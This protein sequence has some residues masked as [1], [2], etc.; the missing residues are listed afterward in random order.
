MKWDAEQYDAGK[1]PQIDAGR[2]LIGLA[3]AREQ[4]SILDL[5]CG[6]GKL[7]VE[8]ARLAPKGRVTGLD[9][10]PEMLDKARAVSGG[11]A[12]LRL[13]QL[14]AQTMEFDDEFDLVFSNS[15]LQ[16]VKEQEDVLHRVYRSLRKGGRIAFQ[17]PMK[18]FC[19][20]FFDAVE[21]A[22]SLLGYERF[23]VG[24]RSP[25]RFST[26]DE[27]ETVLTRTGFQAVKVYIKEY[28]LAFGAVN[29]LVNW[30][31]SAGLRPYLAALPHT[32]QE[33]FKE[34]FGEGFD[35][36]RTDK[37]YEFEFRRLFAFARKE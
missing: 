2:E 16:W 24:W 20:E 3:T 32:A 8:L 7:T 33:H 26:K 25:W 9:P 30:W 23:Y 27:Y 35:R 10:S 18:N 4:D 31:S 19:T 22:T 1:A 13:L 6:T 21:Y 12:N 15:A 29:D 28:H 11:L 17:M 14:P 34:A 37:G 36:S 5:G